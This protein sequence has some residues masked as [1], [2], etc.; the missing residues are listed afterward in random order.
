MAAGLRGATHLRHARD[1]AKRTRSSR[2][3]ASTTCP[4]SRRTRSQPRGDANSLRVDWLA[5][6]LPALSLRDRP[7]I[8]AAAWISSRSDGSGAPTHVLGDVPRATHKRR[9]GRQISPRLGRL[10]RREA[11]RR[12]SAVVYQQPVGVRRRQFG[13]RPRSLPHTRRGYRNRGK[14]AASRRLPA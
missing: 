3:D 9:N 2:V 8:R 11:R 4:V 10:V 5:A 13:D 1:P 7:A 6:R 12:N 14:G